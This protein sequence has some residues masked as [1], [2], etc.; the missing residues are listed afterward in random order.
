[1]P[2]YLPADPPSTT[3]HAGSHIW[4]VHPR[5]KA[6][7]W[8]GPA[9]ARLRSRFD[10]PAGECKMCYFGATLGVALLETLV[11]G[12]RVPLIQRA[13]LEGRQASELLLTRDLTL[14]W[15]EGKGLPALGASAHEVH[16][17]EY[18]ACQALARA[19]HAEHPEMDGIQFRSRWDPSTLC[20]A[21]FDRARNA[22]REVGP[23]RWLGD[24]RLVT[25]ALRP[26]PHVGVI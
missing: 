18:R 24:P 19:V 23:P 17:P 12:R 6:P 21:I 7:L 22:I 10:A 3:L 8:F 26:Y 5:G 1:M 25:P 13:E 16:D 4:R 14:L 9:G 2:L 20:W 11:R 15:L